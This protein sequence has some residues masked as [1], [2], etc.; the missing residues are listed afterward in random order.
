MKLALDLGTRMG[1][2]TY[3]Q[4]VVNCGTLRMDKCKSDFSIHGA[5]YLMLENWL[6]EQYPKPLVIGYEDVKRHA[7]TLAAHA[8]GGYLGV[9]QTYAHSWH[10]P[11]QAYG[12]GEIKKHATGKGN[13]SKD[14]MIKACIDKWGIAP[15]DDNAA[16]A[17]AILAKMVGK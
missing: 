5:R 14:D 10:I 15:I 12:V 11:L 16:D 9:I 4:G 1:W 3:N 2:A 8:Y 6:E 13:A 17:M 7:G